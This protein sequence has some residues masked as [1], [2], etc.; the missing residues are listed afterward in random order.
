MR[1]I[2]ALVLSVVL[3]TAAIPYCVCYA[4]IP[5]YTSSDGQWLYSMI[6]GDEAYISSCAVGQRAY[7]G[8]DSNII[9]PAYIDGHKVFGISKYAFSE[10]DNITCVSFPDSIPAEGLN[11]VNSLGD[12]DGLYCHKGSGLENSVKNNAAMSQKIKYFG[13]IDCNKVVENND[14]ELLKNYLTDEA[15]ADFDNAEKNAADYNIDTAVDAFDLFL[16]DKLLHKGGMS[17]GNDDDESHYAI[18]DWG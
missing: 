11:V 8:T 13:D 4:G 10:I 5:V 3:I 12:V 2:I 14:Y 16:I 18:I 1:K 17:V 9:V 15:S 6:N 7:L